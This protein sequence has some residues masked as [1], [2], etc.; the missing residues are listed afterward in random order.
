MDRELYSILIKRDLINDVVNV[1]DNYLYKIY[2]VEHKNK[3][4]PYKKVEYLNYILSEFN[5]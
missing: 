3:L 4:Y 5:D 2:L 1:I